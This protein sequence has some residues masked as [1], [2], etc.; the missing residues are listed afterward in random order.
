MPARRQSTR[1][2]PLVR[3]PGTSGSK[4]SGTYC[5]SQRSHCSSFIA[6]STIQTG[7]EFR[8]AKPSIRQ[9]T[10]E[11]TAYSQGTKF[12]AFHLASAVF[13]NATRA[14]LRAIAPGAANDS[15]AEFPSAYTHLLR[16]QLTFPDEDF[17]LLE[18]VRLVR[19]TI[20]N[21]GVHRPPS[22]KPAAVIHRGVTYAFPDSGPVDF[23]TWAFVLDLIA[24]LADL[25]DRI[26][27]APALSAHT[28]HIPAPWAEILPP[29]AA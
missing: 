9:V 21:E 4:A 14:L 15:R 26:V 24:D 2:G 29:S 11:Y 17:R 1:F 22:G 19:N 13:E 7:G 28:Q 23:A 25:L 20:H 18:L 12:G 10:F 5:G 3:T 16:T 27:Q 6:T 8:G